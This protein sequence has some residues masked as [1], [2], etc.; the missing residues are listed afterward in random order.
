MPVLRGTRGRDAAKVSTL[1][2]DG[3]RIQQGLENLAAGKMTANCK[4][5]IIRV[6]AFRGRLAFILNS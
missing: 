3:Y 4:S 5:N 2:T 1:I 6:R